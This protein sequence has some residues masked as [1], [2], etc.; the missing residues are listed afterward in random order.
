MSSGM[1]PLLYISQIIFVVSAISKSSMT[2][3]ISMTILSGSAGFFF[4]YIGYIFEAFS[5]PYHE[6]RLSFDFR[7]PVEDH[8]FFLSFVYAYLSYPFFLPLYALSHSSFAWLHLFLIFVFAF[9]YS[10]SFHRPLK[11]HLP[12]NSFL[13][14]LGMISFAIDRKKFNLEFPFQYI[15]Y[16]F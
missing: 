4:W 16:L 5:F 7:H 1:F 3:S 6:Q 11:F 8:V 9:L 15:L 13:Y 14:F 2:D 10:V 12:F